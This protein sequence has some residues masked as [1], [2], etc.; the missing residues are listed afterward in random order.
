MMSRLPTPPP[1]W[2]FW[3]VVIGSFLGYT[4]AVFCLGMI[5]AGAR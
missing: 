5:A 4:V 1:P 2:L 3:F